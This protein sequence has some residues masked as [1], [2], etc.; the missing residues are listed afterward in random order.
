MVFCSFVSKNSPYIQILEEHLLPSLK[1]FN[2]KYDIDYIE[3]KGSWMNNI[4]YKPEFLKKML[5]KHKCPIISLDADA[6]IEQ[7]PNLFEYLQDYDIAAHY[8]DWKKWYKKTYDKKEL[9]GGTLY[10]NYNEKVLALLDKW[11]E[12]QKIGGWPQKNL[13]ELLLNNFKFN[14]YELPVTYCFINSHK[15]PELRKQAVI[16]HYQKSR[17][18]RNWKG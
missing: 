7:N 3:N 12:K 15:F 9:L 17:Q 5:L 18:Y 11:I 1:K 6:I 8:L 2:L 14:I 16:V 4:Q 13:Q 10:L